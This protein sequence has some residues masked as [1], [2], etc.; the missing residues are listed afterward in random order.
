METPPPLAEKGIV[1]LLLV[2]MMILHIS[3]SQAGVRGSL[4]SLWEW[5][6]FGRE[7]ERTQRQ[8]EQDLRYETE[9]FKTRMQNF[10]KVSR[11][12]KR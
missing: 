6:D 12:E 7:R 4:L 11:F 8:M 9:L 3:F 5:T 2:L 1:C 10:S